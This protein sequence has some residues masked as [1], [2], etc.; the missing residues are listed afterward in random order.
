MATT[1]ASYNV[2]FGLKTGGLVDNSKVARNEVQA[3]SRT[4]ASLK[5]PADKYEQSVRVL[6]NALHKGAITQE[7]YNRLLKQAE[8]NY[9]AASGAATK[10]ST[11]IGTLGRAFA[12]IGLAQLARDA[13]KLAAEAENAAIQFEVLL[14][15]AEQA[16]DQIAQMRRFAAQSPLSLNDVQKA[17]ITMK[18]FGLATE[19]VMPSLRML[20]D[21][22]L[23]NS[24][25]FGS[26]ALAFAQTTATGRLMGQE[27]LQ[28]V[29]AGFNPLQQ[30]AR[31]MAKQF[32][33][34]ASDYMPK[35]KKQMEAGAISAQ[36][37]AGA[38]LSATSEGGTFAGMTERLGRTFS[39]QWAQMMDAV[40]QMGI[41]IGR[42]LIPLVQDL[43]D[44]FEQGKSAFDYLL[45]GLQKFTDG[46]R[47]MIALWKDFLHLQSS[48]FDLA[49][50]V[51]PLYGNPLS[52][53]QKELSR[54]VNQPNNTG[55]ALDRIKRR[56][57]ERQQELKDRQQT[58]PDVD[59]RAKKQADDRQAKV[60]QQQYLIELRKQNMLLAA[61]LTEQKATNR[62]IGNLTPAM[63]T[64]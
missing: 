30:I 36:M 16:A 3:L 50:Q 20:G 6:D 4:L 32:G 29:N 13:V 8:N 12:I 11:A 23:G 19:Q 48:G 10:Y 54:F 44:G 41:Q 60:Q 24:E 35:L 52:V 17:A 55:Q 59:T 64:R 33:G 40:Q 49:K 63:A 25:R 31:D 46:T 5:T 28:F 58:Q 45:Y 1:I 26:L 15:S 38:L 22:S 9:Q 53:P 18:A 42:E 43:M 57:D 2:A 37:V 27:V 34:L 47:L 39:G 51:N 14:G 62:Q 56:A 7:R 61:Q 21:I